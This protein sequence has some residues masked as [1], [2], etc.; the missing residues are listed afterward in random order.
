MISILENP[1]LIPTKFIIRN[2]ETPQSTFDKQQKSRRK[3]TKK[4]QEKLILEKEE[5]NGKD[6]TLLFL[7][8]TAYHAAS[9]QLYMSRW[10]S[11]QREAA[12]SDQWPRLQAR[13]KRAD[14]N[15]DDV[16][17]SLIFP[18]WIGKNPSIT[19]WLVIILLWI[20]FLT[21]NILPQLLI[22]IWSFKKTYFI[23]AIPSA[24]RWHSL[25]F[26]ARRLAR[27]YFP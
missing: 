5:G 6:T 11:S 21:F 16:R 20:F 10:V 13:T 12:R 2:R 26:V 7:M 22:L 8:A 23:S 25:S 4:T 15:R 24:Q 9:A 19:F 1:Y 14:T 3:Q 18:L 17:V 27:L